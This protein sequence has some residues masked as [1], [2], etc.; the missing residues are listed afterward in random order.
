MMGTELGTPIGGVGF[1]VKLIDF[2]TVFLS[3][4][5]N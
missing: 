3:E 5:M 4:I 1:V 2:L